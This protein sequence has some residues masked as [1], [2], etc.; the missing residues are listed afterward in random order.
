MTNRL[1]RFRVANVDRSQ[2]SASRSLADHHARAFSSWAVLTGIRQNVL[3]FFLVHSVI[4]DVRKAGSRIEVESKLHQIQ[5]KKE[6]RC[7]ARYSESP[8]S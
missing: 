4:V 6:R 7:R 2:I 5:D 1:S 8:K 3:D